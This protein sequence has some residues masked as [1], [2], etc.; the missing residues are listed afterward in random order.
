MDP[1][2]TVRQDCL[3]KHGLSAT[4]VARVPGVDWQIHSNL[5]NARSG[6]SSEMRCVGRRR[7]AYLPANG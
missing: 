3:E 1:G 2:T 5:L 6:I 7:S 4:D